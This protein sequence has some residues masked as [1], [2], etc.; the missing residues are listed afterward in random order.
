MSVRIKPVRTS[1]NINVR[2]LFDFIDSLF[3]DTGLSPPFSPSLPPRRI[4]GLFL[5]GNIL[6]VMSLD[7][8][9]GKQCNA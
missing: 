3:L 8:Q 9:V 1:F 7:R 4:F 2:R 6:I 5:S